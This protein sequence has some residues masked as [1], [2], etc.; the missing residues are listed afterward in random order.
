MIER[1]LTIEEVAEQL[2]VDVKEVKAMITS[3]QLNAVQLP[4]G[5]IAINEYEIKQKYQTKKT[6]DSYID[7]NAELRAINKSDY[8]RLANVEITYAEALEKYEINHTTF[9]NWWLKG[10]IR[11]INHKSPRTMNEEDAAYCA[12]V[13]QKRKKF[14]CS[15]GWPLLDE[16]GNPNLLKFPGISLYSRRKRMEK[17]RENL[18]PNQKA[19]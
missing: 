3:N 8:R 1:I 13:Y 7:L 9:R 15:H 18:S 12:A 19:A 16:H 4:N 5:G 11:I 17:E 6:T 2:K 10:F 14:G